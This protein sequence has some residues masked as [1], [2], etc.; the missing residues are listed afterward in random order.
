LGKEV[1]FD[2]TKR[3]AD[4]AACLFVGQK[5]WLTYLATEVSSVR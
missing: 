4:E 5:L 1:L 3:H 2:P